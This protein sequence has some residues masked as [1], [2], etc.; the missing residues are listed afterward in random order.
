M[1]SEEVVHEIDRVL[2]EFLSSTRG[3]PIHNPLPPS[4]FMHINKLAEPYGTTETD[5]RGSIL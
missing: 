5:L 4:S 1:T 3:P 2:E